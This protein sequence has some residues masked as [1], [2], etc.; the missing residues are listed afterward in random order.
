LY[1]IFSILALLKYN[2]PLAQ[3]NR[4]QRQPDISATEIVFEYGTEIWVRPIEGKT[5]RRIT[6]TAAIDGDPISPPMASGSLLVP[7]NP[8]FHK[9][10]CCFTFDI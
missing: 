3:P 8:A 10:I 2:A 9:Y 4:L 1:F 6:G 5:A 7:V